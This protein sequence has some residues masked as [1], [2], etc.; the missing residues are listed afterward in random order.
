M[1]G[2]TPAGPVTAREELRAP[3]ELVRYTAQQAALEEFFAAEAK[4]TRSRA[5]LEAAEAD[6][7]VAAG[8]LVAL[9][10]V[11]TA[12]ALTGWSAR[13]IRDAAAASAGPPATAVP[14]NGAGDTAAVG[15]GAGG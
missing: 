7:Q 12:Q 10:D 1:A 15:G 11:S 6:Q 3:L 13:R 8:R 9:C 2:S 14:S 5:A 4:V